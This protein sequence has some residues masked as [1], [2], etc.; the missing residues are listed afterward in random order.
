MP[1]KNKEIVSWNLP[2]Y[3]DTNLVLKYFKLTKF[4]KK[5]IV[6]PDHRY[7]Y[8]SKEFLDYIDSIN[9]TISMSRVGNSLNNREV[10]YF[11][12]ILKTEIFSNFFQK[13]KSLTFDELQAEIDKFINWYNNERFIKKFDLKTPQQI[14]DVYMNNKSIWV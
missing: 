11:F 7:Q 14:R 12:S 4:P 10:E 1:T 13:V 5:F 6:H 8:F 3:N 2:K 9:G